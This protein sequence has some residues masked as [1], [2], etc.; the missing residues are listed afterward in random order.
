MLSWNVENATQLQIDGQ[1]TALTGQR[2]F[3]FQQT[4]PIW[5]TARNEFRSEKICVEVEV[6]PLPVIAFFSTDA[7]MVKEGQRVTL[8]WQAQHTKRIQLLFED[9][10]I[11]VSQNTEYTL[12][13]RRSMTFRLVAHAARDLTSVRKR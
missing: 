3:R 13:L 11:D 12:N 4:R 2:E 8:H 7:L 6:V 9:R 1:D 5:L 10:I